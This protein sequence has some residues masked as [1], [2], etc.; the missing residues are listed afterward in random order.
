MRLFSWKRIVLNLS[1]VA[2]GVT[3]VMNPVCAGDLRDAAPPSVFL[4]VYAKQN[5]ERDYQKKY[6][7]DILKT[8][9]STKIMDRA[10]QMVQ[11]RM[12]ETDVEQ[13]N[14][15]R[16]AVTNAFANVEW[17]KVTNSSETLYVQRM[18]APT[19]HH[20]ILCSMEEGGA[21][22]LATGISNLF[23]LAVNA[24]GGNLT[25]TTET[26]GGVEFTVLQ[27]PPGAPMAPA[28]GVDGNVFVF[29]TSLAFAG[30]SLD[31]YH[32]PDKESKFEDARVVEAMKHL[33]AAEDSI[34][35]YDGAAMSDQLNSMI[36][37][38]RNVAGGNPDAARGID[39]M[40]RIFTEVSAHDFELTVEYTEGF[41][42]RSASYGRMKSGTEEGLMAKMMSHQQAF[43]NW[44][45]W[46]PENASA[47]SLSSGV[48]LHPAYE[49]MMEVIPSV[50]PEAQQG[51]DQFAQIQD[52]IDLHLDADI[53]Q[54]FP[55]ETVSLSFPGKTPSPFGGKSSESA[56][57]MR[58]TN[59]DRIQALLARAMEMI[60]QNQQAKEQGIDM[61]PIEGMEG[62]SEIKANSFGMVGI[63]PVIGFKDGW[64]VMGSHLEAV[65]AALETRS[66][67]GSTIVDSDSFKNFNLEVKGPVQSISYKNNAE[68]TRQAADLMQQLG[69]MGPALISMA[70]KNANGP[71]LQ[72]LIEAAQ[73]LPL[74]SQIVRKFDFIESTMSVTQDGPESGSYVRQSVT[75]IRPP[76]PEKKPA[77]SSAAPAK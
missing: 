8:V 16:D 13:L 9:R 33:P 74:V 17:A 30:E 27:L 44:Q 10:L 18:E 48:N 28:V 42:N 21:S 45:T 60:K 56:M 22:S 76:A 32:N 51:L 41:Q 35:F 20:V 36:E 29:T 61:V 2:V 59:P 34:V 64:M 3:S 19:S 24:S 40:T 23:D 38:V 12:G 37:F 55:G 63:K 65:K 69:I 49:W 77:A 6:Y 75:L 52:Q 54:S 50:F 71:D 58:C 57:F 26:A 11:R 73:L 7:E 4:A 43:E 72:P 68:A 15:V 66:G 14:S 31:Y 25:K 53:L 1:A 70:P 39:L 46:V 62:F 5:P 47:Y 67:S